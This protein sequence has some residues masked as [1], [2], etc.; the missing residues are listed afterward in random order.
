MGYGKRQS[1]VRGDRGQIPS[2]GPPTVAWREDTVKF[3][4]AIAAR[5][6]RRLPP[7]KRACLHPVGVRGSATLAA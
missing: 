6:W 3:W 7:P 1:E 5:S 4:A 2:P